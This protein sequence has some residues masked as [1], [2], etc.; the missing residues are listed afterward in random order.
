MT[1]LRATTDCADTSQ[2][3]NHNSACA[4]KTTLPECT[5]RKENGSSGH[6]ILEAVADFQIGPDVFE[7]AKH[8]AEIPPRVT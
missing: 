3:A 8:E 1:L 4:Y 6:N 2:P 7:H 5:Q